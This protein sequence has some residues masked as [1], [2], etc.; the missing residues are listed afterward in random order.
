MALGMVRRAHER[1]TFYVVK[2]HFQADL[3]VH[4]KLFGRHETLNGQVL[5]RRLEVLA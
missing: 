3:P 5:G 2:S 4:L 1:P